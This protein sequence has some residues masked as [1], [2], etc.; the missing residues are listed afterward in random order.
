MQPQAMLQVFLNVFHLGMD[1]Q[2]AINAPRV[3]TWS[4]PNSFAPFEYR[5]NQVALEGR[6]DDAFVRDL[7]RRGHAVERWPAFTRDAA[8]VEAI[9][10]DASSG[11]LR[12][13]ADPRQPADA[14][15]S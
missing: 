6:Y 8:A 9:Y 10:A 4:F 14:I 15:A 5:P 11:F 1:L 3:S 13:A 7:E 12:A 2:Q